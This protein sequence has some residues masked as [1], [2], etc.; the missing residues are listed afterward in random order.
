MIKRIFVFIVVFTTFAV[1]YAIKAEYSS[2]FANVKSR[3]KLDNPERMYAIW[4]GKDGHLLNQPYLKGGQIVLQWADIEK[5][6][7]VY[8]WSIMDNWMK[9]YYDLNIYATLQ[10]NG[11]NKPKWMFGQIPYYPGKLS[12]QVKDDYTLMF[13]HPRFKQAYLD[14]I[15]AWAEHLKH[16]PYLRSI[17]GVRMNLNPYGT[18]HQYP[19]KYVKDKGEDFSKWVIPDG[20]MQAKPWNQKDVSQYVKDVLDQYVKELSP[21]VKVFVRN[22]IVEDLRREYENDFRE[23]RLA[24]FHTSSEAESRGNERQYMVFMDY[25]RA[26]RTYAYA[27]P[28][29]SAWGEHGGVKDPRFCSPS[30]W[31]YW[32][33]LMDINCGVSFLATYGSDL[34]IPVKGMRF[35]KKVSD[36]MKNEFRSAFDFG[37]KYVGKHR[38]PETTP[39]VWAAF[40]QCDSSLCWKKPLRYLTED[41]TLLTLVQPGNSVGVHNVGSDESRYG[42]W[43]RI[44]PENGKMSVVM[45]PSFV[46]ANEG[47]Q[48]SIRVIYLDD[49]DNQ[50]SVSYGG[51]DYV[52]K[53]TNSGK[54]KEKVWNVKGTKPLNGDEAGKL[55]EQ[56]MIA[57]KNKKQI[58]ALI[59]DITIK[60]LKGNTIFHLLEVYK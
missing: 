12:Q 2:V 20:D 7:G 11:N 52:V 3:T 14:F 59:P 57:G 24:W 44:L 31:N 4:I 50:W 21:I 56:G 6:P 19:S 45:H 5:G 26:G 34:D 17:I 10:V 54:W 39:G 37:A 18:E 8:D 47:S 60:A 43:A 36:I 48:M 49:G 33:I 55:V 53:N 41:Y 40:R 1:S 58:A 25:C 29:A 23:G 32:R 38:Y 35:G 51:K 42:A 22:G 28:W 27:E 16:S 46:K 13:W 15:K 30:Q 9:R